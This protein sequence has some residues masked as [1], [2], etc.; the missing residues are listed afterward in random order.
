MLGPPGFG[1]AQ[2]FYGD[3]VEEALKALTAALASVC[4]LHMLLLRGVLNLLRG[5]ETLHEAWVAAPASRGGVA[6]QAC[7]VACA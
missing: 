7:V 6:A 2:D 4:D 3:G 5:R 1:V